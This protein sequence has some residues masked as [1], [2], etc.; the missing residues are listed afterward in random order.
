MANLG[1][2][3]VDTHKEYTDI[4]QLT[5]ITIQEGSIY[6]IQPIDCKIFVRLGDIGKGFK[7]LNNV[8]FTYTAAA[9]ETLYICTP[10]GRAE[11]NIDEDIPE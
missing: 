5:G 1:T 3:T 6:T 4:E 10:F 11:I 8:I 7:V 2:W 9:D